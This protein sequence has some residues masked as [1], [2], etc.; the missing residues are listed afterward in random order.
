MALSLL[1]MRKLTLHQTQPSL[2][3]ALASDIIYVATKFILVI[4]L[5]DLK[6]SLEQFMELTLA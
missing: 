5:Q 3:L 4:L 2:F 1:D 6:V